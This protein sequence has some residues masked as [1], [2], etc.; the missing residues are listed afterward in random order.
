MIAGLA[1]I[2]SL[3]FVMLNMPI[4]HRFAIVLVGLL[5]EALVLLGVTLVFSMIS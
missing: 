5:A 3:V 2:L 1:L 4:D